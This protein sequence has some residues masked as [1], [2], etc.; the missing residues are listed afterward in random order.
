MSR[1]QPSIGTTSRSAPMPKWS[2]KRRAISPIVMPCRIGIG[3]HADERLE[4]RH[5]HHAFDLRA[6]DR[7]GPVADDDLQAVLARGLQAVRHRVDVGVDADADVLQVDDEHVEVGQ[8]LRRRLARLAVE[9]IHRHAAHLV[10]RVPR[11]DH[12]V[13]HIRAEPVLRAEDRGQGG[14]RDA[15]PGGRRCGAARRRPT[16]DCRRCRRGA[17]PGG[18]TRAGGRTPEIQAFRDYRR[19]AVLRPVRAR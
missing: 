10:V 6:A 7:V 4:T 15:P 19:G 5:E 13:L 9:R 2:L 3:I 8:H 17:R 18:S 1:R 14:A 11:L 16:R 12:V